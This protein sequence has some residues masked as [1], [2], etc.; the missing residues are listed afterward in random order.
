MSNLVSIVNEKYQFLFGV[1][2]VFFILLVILGGIK[3]ILKITDNFVPIFCILYLLILITGILINYNKLG[4]IIKLIFQSA[5]NVKAAGISAFIT[6]F[7]TAI[8]KSI[9]S[10]EAGLGTIPS[11]TGISDINEKEVVSYY[12]LLGVIVDTVVFCSLTG[13]FIL[14]F[15]EGY[16]GKIELLLPYCFNKYLG[17]IGLVIYY[18]LIIFFGLT[19]VFGLYYLGE[20][21]AMFISQYSNILYK[22][23]KLLYQFGFIIG[24]VIGIVGSFAKIMW[25]VDVGILLLGS[26][27][28]FILCYVEKRY[29]LLKNIHKIT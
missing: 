16:T 19:S 18:I 6:M 17:N 28:L 23:I 5:F 25:L 12:Q 24:I 4:Y 20:N 22:D 10:N 14:C 3:R 11:L 29:K 2:L 26:L 7:K 15:N 13:I 9:F 21:N 27:N 8:T 1:I